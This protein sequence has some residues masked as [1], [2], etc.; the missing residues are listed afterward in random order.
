MARNTFSSTSFA[1]MLCGL[2]VRL[3]L[4]VEDV[5]KRQVYAQ[6]KV[7]Q[8]TKKEMAKQLGVSRPT[9]DRLLAEFTPTD[10]VSYTHLGALKV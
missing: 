1:L 2:Q 8:I 6:Y 10:P 4:F 3:C 7:R 5:Y 9:L